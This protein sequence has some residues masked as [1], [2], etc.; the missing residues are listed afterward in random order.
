MGPSLVAFWRRHDGH[1]THWLGLSWM[2][3]LPRVSGNINRLKM[4]AVF[5]ARN[6]FPDLRSYHVLLQTDN[7][8]VVAYIITRVGCIHAPCSGWCSRSSFGLKQTAF[9]EGSFHPRS[10]HPFNAGAETWGFADLVFLLEGSLLDVLTR[11]DLRSET[12]F[13]PR[14]KIWKLWVWPLTGTSS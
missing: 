13:H 8:S 3:A 1:L 5:L 7:T 6:F 14:P 4:R 11:R 9:P 10:R 2:V 12:I